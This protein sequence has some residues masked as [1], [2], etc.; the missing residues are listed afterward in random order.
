MEVITN[1]RETIVNGVRVTLAPDG[2]AVYL[3]ADNSRARVPFRA[4]RLVYPSANSV[5]TYYVISHP[6]RTA[7]A[8]AEAEP[9]AAL[10]EAA[11]IVA[12]EVIEFDR[13]IE[14]GFHDS[15]VMAPEMRDAFEATG[16]P[17]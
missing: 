9:A 13:N 6:L 17:V 7:A 3:Y 2:D 10:A 11:R 4:R 8:M 15:L 16:N 14:A 12:N 1:I 5:R